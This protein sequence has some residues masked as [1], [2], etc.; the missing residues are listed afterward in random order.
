MP[1]RHAHSMSR[2]TL[3]ICPDRMAH[4]IGL[5]VQ[6]QHAFERIQ[7]SALGTAMALSMQAVQMRSS[8]LR[9][10]RPAQAL[11]VRQLDRLSCQL[12]PATP[13]GAD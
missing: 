2:Q 7:T 13:H 6:S 9:S 3:R 1:R 10:A 12:P 8:G 5:P 11:Q 4:E